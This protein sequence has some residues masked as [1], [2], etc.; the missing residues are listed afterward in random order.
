[1]CCDFPVVEMNEFHER[2]TMKKGYVILGAE[3]CVCFGGR[4]GG[5]TRRSRGRDG[6]SVWGLWV[7]FI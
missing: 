6:V 1:M 7:W 3:V 2:V 4:G 5:G